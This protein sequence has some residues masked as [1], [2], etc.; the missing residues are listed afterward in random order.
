LYAVIR[1]LKSAAPRGAG[2]LLLCA[3][4]DSA[5][6]QRYSFKYYGQEAGLRN[7]AI[8]CLQ[9]DRTGFLWVGTQ[10]GL[11]R[12]D[13]RSFLAFNAAD[14]LPA[15][16]IESLHESP[17]GTLWVGTRKGLARRA[18]DRFE[19]VLRDQVREILNQS[20][21]TSDAR[22]RLFIGTPDG[23]LV[24]R[25]A[26]KEW[27]F[28]L[29][30]GP[31][32]SG[33]AVYGVHVD[34]GG[35]VWYGCGDG[36]CTFRDGRVTRLADQGVPPDRWD[37]IL[38]DA[39]GTVWARSV[40]HL[41]ARRAGTTLF[42]S[43]DRGLPF[44]ANF[45][46]LFLDPNGK[47]V[48]PTNRGL[49]QAEARGWR[50]IGPSHGLSSRSPQCYLIDREG[51]IWIGMNGAGL[52]KW[53][54]YK[55]W[56]SWSEAEG[57]SHDIV[58]SIARDSGGVLWVGTGDGLNRLDRA[59]SAWR[60][61]KRGIGEAQ[62]RALLPLPDGTLL[63]GLNPGGVSHLDP[64]RGEIQ[65]YS[66]AAGLIDD[67]VSTLAID[68]SNRVWAGGRGGLYRGVWRSGKLSFRREDLPGSDAN[69]L[70]FG[71]KVDRA[72]RLW[73]G[74]SR[75]LARLEGENW[76]R[77]T[78][79]D[80]LRNDYVAY[81]AEGLDGSIWIG[82]REAA[83]LSQLVFE[84]SRMRVRHFSMLEGLRSDQAIFVGVDTRGWIWYG[85]DDG[86]DVYDGAN[87]KHYGASEGL[88][89]DD[90]DGNAFYADADG[91]VWI[92]TSK[93][94]S[95]YRPLFDRPPAPARIPIVI[96]S[97][98]LGEKR[99]QTA[100]KL[101]VSYGERS[102]AAR[103]AALSFRNEG[104]VKFW[105][106]LAGLE[107][108]WTETDRGE[109]RYP[110]L[111]AGH[112]VF[113]VRATNSAGA[114]TTAPARV[115]FEILP[116]W[117]GSRWFYLGA[118]VALCLLA[119]ATWRWRLR[120]MI[121][122]Q[123]R[124]EAAVEER[125]EKLRAG[126]E[127]VEKQKLE[128]E[129]LLHAAEQATR[130]KSEFLA[131]MSHEIRTPMNGVVG[132]TDLA[133]AAAVDAEQAEYLRLAKVSANSLLVLIN[134]IL[135]FSK[136]EAGRLDLE[137]AELPLTHM[138]NDLVKTFVPAARQKQ[139]TIGCEIGREVPE[140][141]MGDPARLRQI[142]INLLGNAIKFTRRGGII[143]AVQQEPGNFPGLCLHFR[144][145]DTGIG[146][147]PEQQKAI[148]EPFRQADGSTTRRY[149]GTGLGLAISSR[150]V[151]LMGGRMWVE[152][153]AGEGST[154]HFTALFEIPPVGLPP[155]A[156]AE[157]A[158][159]S[160]DPLRLLRILLA[161][162]NQINQKLARIVLEKRGH[163]VVVAQDGREALQALERSNFDLVLMDVQ[164]PGMDGFEA[165]AAIRALEKLTGGH[166]PIVAMTANAMRGDRERCLEAGMDGYVAKP[167]DPRAL[168]EAI[169][170][171][172]G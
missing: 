16:R 23:L 161:E 61:W 127:T 130:L 57:L 107:D 44:S 49:A 125:T 121:E 46:Q 136:I 114:W 72:G 159:P 128:I 120:R 92:G 29:L 119:R 86:V 152:S 50:F 5:A 38:T 117:W 99:R 94:L 167:V 93:G 103:F 54:G 149:G 35:T 13:G 66:Q 9:Q 14:G 154:F 41:L 18:G 139:L 15:S 80:G 21:I 113:E 126:K 68:P 131:N 115:E 26:D 85:S 100:A 163:T 88:I 63:A 135:D 90:C 166:L 62:I 17:D 60:V 164:M 138:L 8:H 81:I 137:R 51:S 83:G 171:A 10:N 33:Q 43:R 27:S 122:T 76:R 145:R 151:D 2:W 42:V 116:P 110:S 157:S 108:R 36:I 58:W 32:G 97:F 47:L 48:V 69:E 78:T 19:P 150:L 73:I 144:V 34:A 87:W 101:A 52:A 169:D 170:A 64:R 105:Y 133:L 109:A 102:L 148:F 112:Y 84:G 168:F 12:Y 140:R 165:T 106:R 156:I 25:R 45:G 20:G 75:G 132:M 56:E 59:G 31:P 123:E 118:L 98:R 129:R 91:G 155:P 65:N 104:A 160:A 6:A 79:A 158:A 146:I 147:A 95:H 1:A 30:R 82:Y 77:F 22:G 111:P 4:A 143:V 153:R 124:L 28:Q 142:L 39:A 162:D 40:R 24:G 141:L 89:W 3:L 37:A 55:E 7:L 67:N 172:A 96:T 53:L 70:I 11:Y 74:G 71:T 134:D